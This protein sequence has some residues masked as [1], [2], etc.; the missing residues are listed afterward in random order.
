MPDD[1][2][3]DDAAASRLPPTPR[4]LTRRLREE[5]PKPVEKEIRIGRSSPKEAADEATPSSASLKSPR[6]QKFKP[7]G[8]KHPEFF[9]GPLAIDQNNSDL[10]V[11]ARP[12]IKHVPPPA[13][14]IISKNI[15]IILGVLFLLSVLGMVILGTL[16]IRSA[17]STAS[18]PPPAATPPTAAPDATPLPASTPSS[19]PTPPD[20]FSTY[21]QRVESA[22]RLTAA[23][24]RTWVERANLERTGDARFLP[25][26]AAY[27]RS[28]ITK[29]PTQTDLLPLLNPLYQEMLTRTPED[30]S[31]LLAS[32]AHYMETGAVAP[33]MELLGRAYSLAPLDPEVRKNYYFALVSSGERMLARDLLEEWIENE[34][35]NLSYREAMVGLLIE[36]DRQ[37][38]A[39][40]QLEFMLRAAPDSK[41]YP[42]QWLAL[43]MKA[44]QLDEGLELLRSMVSQAPKNPELHYALGRGCLAAGHWEQAA[45]ALERTRA[46]TGEDAQLSATFLNELG[47][48]LA[49]TGDV[50]TG[51]QQLEHALSISNEKSQPDILNNLAYFLSQIPGRAE[52]AKS[53]IDQAIAARPDSAAFQ[54]TQGLV[55]MALGSPEEALRAFENANTGL[56]EAN[57]EV[58][59]SLGDALQ[60]LG[61]TDKAREAWEHAL[62]LEPDNG[63]VKRRLE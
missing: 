55:L 53:Y 21:V 32:A 61:R 17:P 23:M 1:E 2:S 57:A 18:V 24:V 10:P 20:T 46:L 3:N 52:E 9:I 36:L 11:P 35:A 44:G 54:H 7:S 43:M 4:E 34:P 29:E 31:V 42:H 45:E 59:I 5:A 26:F 30:V 47:T 28:A 62:A 39:Q 14:P 27:L 37:A 56:R 48:A 33:A 49:R 38:E 60:A 58:I 15:A 16:H 51:I 63:E 22:D 13:P 40:E 25:Q 12:W 6:P 50:D 41:T 8:K 19:T